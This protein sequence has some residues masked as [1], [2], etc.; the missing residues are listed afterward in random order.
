MR[1]IVVSAAQIRSRIMGLGSPLAVSSSGTDE[2]TQMAFAGNVADHAKEIGWTTLA[3]AGTPLAS[4]VSL[5]L[6]TSFLAPGEYGILAVLLSCVVA[7][8]TVA[9]VPMSGPGTTLL[10]EWKKES[11]V[12][13]FTGTLAVFYAA[14]AVLSGV[15]ILIA[16]TLT[17][18][19]WTRAVAIT[20]GCFLCMELVK[21]PV[22]TLTNVARQRRRYALLSFLDG[23]G[24]LGLACGFMALAGRFVTPVVLGYAANSAVVA[25]LGWCTFVRSIPGAQAVARAKLFSHSLLLTLVRRGAPY[26]CIGL[27]NWVMSLSDRVLL[28]ALAPIQMAGVYTAGYQVASLL[29]LLLYSTV[30][31][32]VFP[33][34]YQAYAESP[35]EGARLIGQSMGYML[36]LLIPVTAGTVLARGWLVQHFARHGYEAGS[37]VVAWVAPALA[38]NVLVSLTAMPFWLKDKS[39]NYLALAGV[40]AVFNVAFNAFYIPRMGF[41]AAAISTLATYALL[42]AGTLVAGRK[43]ILWKISRVHLWAACSGSL[44][45]LI[46]Y[47]LLAARHVS[48]PAELI[49]AAA[50]YFMVS[51]GTL[52]LLDPRCRGVVLAISRT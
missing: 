16:A 5:K 8:T 14:L 36:W 40:A 11:R 29:P 50:M 33:L 43:L 49:L 20:A 32:F 30:G 47:G 18:R 34:I 52:L 22:M 25:L 26:F 41:K 39:L 28:G 42:F 45:A 15:V 3:Q 6:F 37:A 35:A 19:G 17:A 1:R 2:T 9:I 23:W 46:F 51:G 13:E 7:I 10:H 12:G 44:A 4:I 24:K 31:M 48:K 21:S 38:L 27:A